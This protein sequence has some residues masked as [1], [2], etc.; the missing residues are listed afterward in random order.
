MPHSGLLT[1]RLWRISSA[2]VV[3]SFTTNGA[4]PFQRLVENV[5]ERE[6]DRSA[7]R[8]FWIVDNGTAHRGVAS[9]ERLGN[10]W[11]NL[12]PVH[13]RFMQHG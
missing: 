4:K 12:I 9:C 11:P 7:D 10:A 1:P 8:V 13:T 3:A 6:P 5:M 2:G